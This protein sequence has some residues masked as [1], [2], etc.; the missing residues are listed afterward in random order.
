MRTK[1]LGRTGLSVPIVGLGTAFLGIATLVQILGEDPAFDYLKKLH[2]NI[3]QYPRSGSAPMRN[4]ARGENAIGVSF[5]AD[6]VGEAAASGLPIR[7]A[8]PCEG[9]GY[10][11]GSMSL[12]KGARNPEGAKRFYEWALTPAVQESVHKEAKSP[13]YASHSAVAAFQ[14]MPRLNEIKFINYD[15]VKYGSSTV[16]SGLLARWEREV[17]SMKD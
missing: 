11:V 17:G 2:R 14:G 12:I 3:S 13:Q 8:T 1:T 10:E 16:R 6:V 4:A 15:F 5:I 7:W 9:T